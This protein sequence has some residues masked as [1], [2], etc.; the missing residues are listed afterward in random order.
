VYSAIAPGLT[1]QFDRIIRQCLWRDKFDEPKQSLAAC[2]LVCLPKENGGLVV[3][4]FQ[5]QNAALLIKFLKKF[6]NN[7]DLPWVSLIWHAHYTDKVPHAADLYG[8]FWWRDVMKQVDNF[9]G[10]SSVKLG[11]GESFMFWSDKWSL[12]DSESPL[13]ERFPRLFSYVLDQDLSARQVYLQEDI[14]NLFYLPLSTQDFQ[15]FH[16]LQALMQAHP[17]TDQVDV[18]SY[19]WGSKYSSAQ[20]YGH[21]HKHIKV[22]SVYKWIWKSCCIM[23]T[24]VFA[25]LVL[26]DRLNTRDL[27]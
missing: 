22:P 11:R 7:M 12:N 21:I 17:L 2:D 20:F 24:K 6:Y 27:L 4:N 10:I 1:K 16:D 9:R 5:K 15:E 25:W 18:W 14:I 26:R 13:K 23:R 19:T 3:V 8:S